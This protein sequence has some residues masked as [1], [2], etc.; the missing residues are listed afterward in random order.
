MNRSKGAGAADSIQMSATSL[1]SDGPMK[2]WKKLFRL[3]TVTLTTAA[4]ELQ[5]RL[6][7]TEGKEKKKKKNGA[8]CAFERYS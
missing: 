1:W 2:T 7:Q 6:M 8:W 5:S 4:D 3:E